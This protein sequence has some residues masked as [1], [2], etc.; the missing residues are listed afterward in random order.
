MDTKLKA[1]IIGVAAVLWIGYQAVNIIR[2]PL[3]YGKEHTVSFEDGSKVTMKVWE[4]DDY[5]LV[6]ETNTYE[7]RGMPVFRFEFFSA[8]NYAAL[9]AQAERKSSSFKKI[10]SNGWMGFE[11]VDDLQRLHR[12]LKFPT[13]VVHFEGLLDL[14]SSREAIERAEF[15]YVSE[16]ADSA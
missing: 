14:E 10:V 7:L 8:D 1:L 16:A 5:S 6:S 11:Y 4:S 13:V 3:T 15:M 9:Q 2:T 12:Y